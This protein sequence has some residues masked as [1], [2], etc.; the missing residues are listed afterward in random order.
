M[1]EFKIKKQCPVRD[2]IDMLE[3]SESNCKSAL[4]T[5]LM[6]NVG[7]ASVFNKIQLK[8]GPVATSYHATGSG[9][10]IL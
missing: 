6:K 10:N 7:L 2:V 1:T 5:A 4:K 9:N 3:N 8:S